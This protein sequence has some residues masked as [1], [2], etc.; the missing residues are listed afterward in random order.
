[1]LEFKNLKMVFHLSESFEFEN[2][3]AEHSS[4]TS[5][6]DTDS[7]YVKIGGRLSLYYI[8]LLKLNSHLSSRWQT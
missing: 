4:L 5:S 3:G 1:M 7:T 6:T 2:I 8:V